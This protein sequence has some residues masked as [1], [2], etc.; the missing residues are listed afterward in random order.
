MENIIEYKEVLK[1]LDKNYYIND[2]RYFTRY[3]DVQEWGNQIITSLKLI[4]CFNDELTEEVFKTWAFY[5]GITEDDWEDALR[6][7]YLRASW[8]P[9]YAMDLNHEYDAEAQLMNIL[10]NEL[11]KEIDI[12]IIKELQIQTSNDYLSV[13]RCLG[14]EPGPTIYDPRTFSPIKRFVAL[15]NN[16][17]QDERQN[18]TY[19]QDWIR[20]RG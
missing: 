1:Y 18:N 4:F 12:E 20:T 6:P 19:W 9:E 15:T 11:S 17:I 10:S 14:Y 5:N 3:G 8:T 16:E 13:V 7:R 2:S